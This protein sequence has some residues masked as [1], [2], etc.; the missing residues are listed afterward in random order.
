V[1]TPTTERPADFSPVFTQTDYKPAT[2][3]YIHTP[4]TT[5]IQGLGAFS[6]WLVGG[7]VGVVGG[8]RQSRVYNEIRIATLCVRRF[9]GD[10]RLHR[11]QFAVEV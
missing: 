11:L 7:V 10:P 2:T 4:P 6:V 3:D 5:D 8:G 1:V 9:V